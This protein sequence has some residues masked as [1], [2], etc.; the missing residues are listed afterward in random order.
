MAGIK[1]RIE[2]EIGSQGPAEVRSRTTLQYT[3]TPP[4]TALAPGT[5][6][7]GALDDIAELWTRALSHKTSGIGGVSSWL[8]ALREVGTLLIAV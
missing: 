6:V 7:V 5:L 4:R 1:A 8:P 2:A 3:A